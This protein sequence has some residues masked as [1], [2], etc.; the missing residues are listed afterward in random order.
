MPGTAQ[1]I[2]AP[3][4]LESYRPDIVVLMNPIYEDEVR[5]TLRGHGIDA[6]LVLV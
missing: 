5:G 6:K 1:E 2:V 4:F 3:A